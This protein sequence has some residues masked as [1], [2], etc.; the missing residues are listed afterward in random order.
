MSF[1]KITELV[2]TIASLS[3]LFY[4]VGYINQSAYFFSLGLSSVFLDFTYQEYVFF[5]FIQLLS[6]LFFS[7]LFFDWYSILHEIKINE[8]RLDEIR[9]QIILLESRNTSSSALEKEEINE[10]K[11]RFEDVNKYVSDSK[12]HFFDQDS[13]K[14]S[15]RKIF[16]ILIL[17]LMGLVYLFFYNTSGI[18]ILSSIIQIIFSFFIAFSFFNQIKKIINKKSKASYSLILILLSVV[19]F[20]L[21]AFSG[22]LEGLYKARNMI[23]T[24]MKVTT[25]DNTTFDATLL[26]FGNDIYIFR[27]DKHIFIPNSEIKKMESIN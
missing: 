4:F 18:M 9:K 23:N 21:P 8:N 25:Q 7:P 16:F 24:K 27:N 10:L 11:N 22:Y 13:F 1:K 17:F 3:F 14:V 15:L 19:F 20:F 12:K 26:G 2:I 5:G 6:F